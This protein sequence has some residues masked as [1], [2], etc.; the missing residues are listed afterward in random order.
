[1]I[2]ATT[3]KKTGLSNS[4][5]TS[6]TLGLFEKIDQNGFLIS[7]DNLTITADISEENTVRILH[8]CQAN[9]AEIYSR[10]KRSYSLSVEVDECKFYVAYDK[11]KEALNARTFRIE[12]N[13][14]NLTELSRDWVLDKVLAKVDD[15]SK[16]ISRMDVAF[17]MKRD[18][19]FYRFVNRNTKTSMFF[20]QSGEVET[21]YYGSSGSPR[22][23]RLYDK[24]REM[25]DNQG[26]TIDE[27]HYWRFEVQLRHKYVDNW[28]D[29]LK[30]ISMVKNDF[31]DL[32]VQERAMVMYLMENPSGY[33]ELSKNA[34]TKYRKLINA[35]S[36][37]NLTA[38]LQAALNDGAE[39][40]L[41]D[42]INSWVDNY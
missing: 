32:K 11:N 39:K 7:I 34:R 5:S 16:K 18:L 30:N 38:Q 22:Q 21:L 27:K 35:K 8:L 26:V 10:Y 14:N 1:M 37:S 17:D 6:Q 13:P 2:I 9:Q 36:T 28:R 33:K 12:F 42:M 41:S 24:K 31:D 20:G 19:S 4:Q 25:L 29:M 40:K 3:D 15:G 23:V